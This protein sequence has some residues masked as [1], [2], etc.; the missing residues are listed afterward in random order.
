MDQTSMDMMSEFITEHGDSFKGGT[1]VD[2]GSQDLNG[3]YR[4][5][6]NESNYIGADIAKGLNVDILMDSDEWK[7]L[8]DVDAVISGQTFEHIADRPAMMKTIYNVLKPGGFICIISPSA[9]PRHDYPV[10]TGNISGE[11]LTDLATD[12]GFTVL[13]IK[14]SD[15]EPWHLTRCIA[16]KEQSAA[17]KKK[18]TLKHEIK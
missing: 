7:K 16:Q 2:I 17:V 14:V 11:M 10:W 15:E 1:V 6:F 13:D 5:L 4:E 9:G 8:K 12:S 18:D 3:S